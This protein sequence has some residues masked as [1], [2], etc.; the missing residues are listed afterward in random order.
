MS[1]IASQLKEERAVLDKRRKD[2]EEQHLYLPVWVVTEAIFNSHQGFDLT[3]WDSENDD[4]AK[5]QFHRVLKVS[6]VADLI[7]R[8]AESQKISPENIR[9][10]VMVNRQNKTVRP[11]HPLEDGNMTVETA[12][13]KFGARDRHF[14]LWAEQ[15]T[16]FDNGKPVWT[17]NPATNKSS[18]PPIL[19][20]LKHFDAESQTLRGVGH[21]YLR[22]QAKV[23]DLFP[24]IVKKLGWIE[25]SNAMTNG[26]TNGNLPS[27]TLSLYEEIKS[28]MIEPM[29][30]KVTLQHAEIQDGD[31]VCFQRQLSEKQVGA[32]ASAGNYTDAREFYDYLL[33]RKTVIFS[34]KVLPEDHDGVFKLDLSKKMSYEQFSAKVGEYLKVEPTHLRFSTV[35]ST[36]GKA[37]APV[38]RNAVQTLNQILSPAFG[39]YGGGNQREDSLYYEILDMSLSELDT[40]K[41][42]KVTYLTDGQAKEETYDLL[43]PKMGSVADLY[44]ILAKKAN[45]DR[46]LTSKLRIYETNNAK[47]YREYRNESP[48]SILSEYSN[49]FVE[50]IPEE[51][52][53]A[54]ENSSVIS[55][56]HYDK[57]PNKPHGIPF[58]F[59]VKQVMIRESLWQIR[60]E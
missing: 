26:V 54:E 39:T 45:F 57:D 48:I 42:L 32:L 15:A 46:D 34:P 38:R 27:P 52:R 12:Y 14:R 8:V 50:I 36:T 25:G 29:K 31:I 24:L 4:P 23:S 13:V 3:S 18:D 33:N 9:L 49:L 17:E 5:P 40:K 37:K 47:I 53:K 43:V 58:R 20:F 28:S 11:D 41:N 56:Y 44:A 16:T 30:P 7:K 35:N 2:K 6:T 21:V 51:E 59:V 55:C 60:S 19:I 1:T 10:W 22:R